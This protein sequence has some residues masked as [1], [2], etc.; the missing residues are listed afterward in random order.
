MQSPS[1]RAGSEWSILRGAV[2]CRGLRRQRRR[3]PDNAVRSPAWIA[4][5]FVCLAGATIGCEQQTPTSARVAGPREATSPVIRA[6][7]TPAVAHSLTSTGLFPTVHTTR[8]GAPTEISSTL[9]THLAILFA[10][11]FLPKN[12]KLWEQERGARI[13]FEHLGPCGRVYYAESVAKSL[14]PNVP[15]YDLKNAQAPWW[16]VTLCGAD[17]A[18][19]F[20][21]SV[22]AWD[23]DIRIADDKIVFPF[24]DGTSF[25]PEPVPAD[26][27]HR[28]LISPERAAN[29][30]SQLTGKR[31][32]APP[33]L[34]VTPG[35]N[36]AESRWLVTT[37]DSAA[38]RLKKDPNTVTVTNRFYVGWHW[39]EDWGTGRAVSPAAGPEFGV[40]VAVGT[41]L[42]RRDY[43]YYGAPIG[44]HVSRLGNDRKH[45]LAIHFR[46]NVAVSTE[47]VQGLAGTG[48]F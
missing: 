33:G 38:V 14:P 26:T 35:V 21:V 15:R 12:Q 8:P 24:V 22:N 7:L 40:G 44:Q 43:Y 18:P 34:V 45:S 39:G 23:T 10:R 32:S 47:A 6:G 17:E 20:I 28:L 11:D 27:S 37:D 3:G 4:A 42:A 1:F 41:Q 13:D 36:P 9:A 16:L 31:I 29:M 19:Q 25:V 48:G 2:R 5:M 30:V 46:P